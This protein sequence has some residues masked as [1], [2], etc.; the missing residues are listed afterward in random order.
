[1]EKLNHLGV[2]QF[3]GKIII[4]DPYSAQTIWRMTDDIRVVPGVY[5]AFALRQ[6]GVYS[7]PTVAELVWYHADSY[8]NVGHAASQVWEPVK[9]IG[10]DSGQAGIFDAGIFQ[11]IESGNQKSDKLLAFSRLCLKAVTP[12]HCGCMPTGNGVVSVCGYGEDDYDVFAIQSND[13]TAY[14]AIALDFGYVDVCEALRG[15]TFDESHAIFV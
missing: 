12:A 11:K 7:C 10:V 8:V 13:D 5:H 3:G 9:C 2:I 1:M 6:H 4:A 14:T 15:L